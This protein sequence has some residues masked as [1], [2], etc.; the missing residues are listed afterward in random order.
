MLSMQSQICSVRC[1]GYPAGRMRISPAR[2]PTKFTPN[3]VLDLRNVSYVTQVPVVQQRAL[4]LTPP[5]IDQRAFLTVLQDAGV[6]APDA[7]TRVVL[8][9]GK[10]FY[11]LEAV[12]EELGCSDTAL[13]RIGQLYPFPKEE[14]ADALAEFANLTEVI[15]AQE[16][17]K[18]HG[19]WRF[20]RE[21]WKTSFLRAA[22]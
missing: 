4:A 22:A 6:T 16:E 17:D 3:C 1:S 11:D 10:F 12:R 7:V 9:S 5:G 13:I 19:A 20:V 15:W 8:C 14:L 18:N 21:T 2:P